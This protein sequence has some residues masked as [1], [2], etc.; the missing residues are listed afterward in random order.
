MDIR[1]TDEEEAF[2]QELQEFLRQEL[3]DDWD[4]L[5]QVSHS[6]PQGFPFTKQMSKKLADKGWLTLAW[7]R[8]YGGQERSIMEQVVYSE[9][10]SYWGAPGTDLGTGAISWVGPVLMIA[11]TEE[12]KREHLPPIA[13]AE[14]YWC[15]LYSEPGA[16]SDLASL[17]T[18]AVLDGDDYVINGQKIW[19]SSAHIAD[20]GWLAA[21]TDPDVPKHRGISLF[22]LDMKTPGVSV[23]PIINMAGG[24]EFNEVFFEDVRVPKGNMVGEENRGW[25]T[26]AV[27]LDFERSGVGYSATARR[28]LE[29]LVDYARETRHNGGTLADDPIV[30]HKLASRHVETEVSRW[31][32]YRVAW[33]QS[34]GLSPNAEASMSKLY[35]TELTQRVAQT[36]MELLGLAG[37]LSRGSRWAPLQGYIQ[38]TYLGSPSATIAAGTSEIQRDIIARRGLGLPR[39]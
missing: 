25:Y 27:A 21:R 9:E 8:E 28:T 31:L 38:R 33:M 3:P 7:P 23:R 19:T 34:E 6:S 30:R 5:N 1:F 17:Q 4:P 39:G 26:V 14:R 37:Q 16:G 11:G 29:A 15:T 35:G 12:Q 2:R 18:S 24:H 22:L 13:R 32:S 10:M 20:W 36:G